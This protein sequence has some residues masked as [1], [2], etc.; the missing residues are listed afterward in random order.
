[1]GA[2]PYPRSYSGLNLIPTTSIKQLVG[3][4]AQS[5][6]KEDIM[7]TFCA[8][9]AIYFKSEITYKRTP[10]VG[11]ALIDLIDQVLYDALS[12]GRTQR[13]APTAY[14]EKLLES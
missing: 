4:S 3:H 7:T 5:C 1:M 11:V 9:K 6:G 8:T 13:S 2:T 10:C 14:Q 12:S